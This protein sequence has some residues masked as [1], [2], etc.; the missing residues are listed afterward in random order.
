MLHMDHNPL[1]TPPIPTATPSPPGLACYTTSTPGS[2]GSQEPFADTD[3][4]GMTASETRSQPCLLNNRGHHLFNTPP[5]RGA[6]HPPKLPGAREGPR[7]PRARACARARARARNHSPAR[8]HAHLALSGPGIPNGRAFLIAR[9][10]GW[11]FPFLPK[12]IVNL[13]S[14]G[15]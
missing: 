7:A 8:A 2:R 11:P 14:K 4:K 5:R 13:M 9:T 15:R 10:R 1:E 3:T 12:D 6:L